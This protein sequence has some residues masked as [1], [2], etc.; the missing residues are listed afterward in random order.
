MS[1]INQEKIFDT[2][3]SYGYDDIILMPGFIDFGVND[4]NL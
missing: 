1:G 3:E 2:I 4:V